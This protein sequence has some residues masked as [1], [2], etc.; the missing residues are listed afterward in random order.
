MGVSTDAMLCYGF[1]VEEGSE[2]HRLVEQAMYGYD[3]YEGNNHA[4]K[5]RLKALS[6]GVDER[7]VTH[8]SD[9]CRMYIV[10]AK[11]S[12]TLAWRGSPKEINVDELA[13]RFM[14]P[15][16]RDIRGT[17]DLLGITFKPCSWLLCSYWG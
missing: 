10:C 2:D 15:Y 8:C 6:D 14:G 11:G 5:A 9:E 3:N 16:E 13:D 7:I 4:E 12:D 17:C 1:E